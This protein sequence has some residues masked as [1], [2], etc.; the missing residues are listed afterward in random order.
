[1]RRI[2]SRTARALAVAAVPVLIAGCSGSSGSDS[3]GSGSSGSS[4]AP[5]KPTTPSA[6]PSLAP[7]KYT[8]LP[9]PCG[10]L[11][12]GTIGDLVPN[13]KASGGQVLKFSDPDVHAGCD[14]TGLDGYEYH[15]LGVDL[16]RSE[17]VQGVGSAEDQAK[18][19]FTQLKQSTTAPDGLKKGSAPYIHSIGL[20]D[21]S[22]LVSAEVS[23]DKTTYRNVTVIVRQ[24]NVILDVS[25]EG[26]GFE[27]SKEPAAK[28]IEADAT[29]AAKE[30]LGHVGG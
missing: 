19:Q 10:T 30:A 3:S 5:A 20:G 22:Q 28:D 16:R 2:A 15:Y 4:A 17:T 18:T 6:A 9:E 12:K 27:G 23:K 29:K 1:M 8:Q 7:A 11:S 24:A 21:D 13:A 14:W 25:Y 26:A